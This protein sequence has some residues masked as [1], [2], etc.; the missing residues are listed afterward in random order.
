M[1]SLAVPNPVKAVEV[2]K[3][4]IRF[5]AVAPAVTPEALAATAAAEEAAKAAALAEAA[6]AEAAAALPEA[7]PGATT[8]RGKRKRRGKQ[9]ATPNLEDVAMK[10]VTT[11]PYG[12][13]I[14]PPMPVAQE[15]PADPVAEEEYP[16]LAASQPKKKRKVKK[17]ER[18]V[19]DP[20]M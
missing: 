5:A 19:I 15:P 7:L 18:A 4:N 3:K 14:L 16:L 11:D 10:T 8:L 20:Y 2:I 17:V 9:T 6:A 1:Q 13:G 12:G